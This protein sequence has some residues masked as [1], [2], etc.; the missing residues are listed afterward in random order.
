MGLPTLLISISDDQIPSS[1]ALNNEGIAKY[2]GH[3]NDLDVKDLY[4][5]IQNFV[6]DQVLL[7]K[8]KQSSMILVDG[9]GA[10]RVAEYLSPSQKDSIYLMP[11]NSSDIVQYF[12]WANDPNVRKNAINTEVISF[13]SHTDW[14]NNSIS[15]ADRIMFVLESAGLPIGQIRFD[16]KEN[17][18]TIDYSIDDIAHG[19]GLATILVQEG[20]KEFSKDFSKE[21]HA[22]VRSENTYSRN[23]FGSVILGRRK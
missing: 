7:Q 3:I 14:F 23:V 1:I 18:A 13:E 17:T 2:A 19:R 21:I 16:I 5:Q 15:N 20:I 10:L 22:L 9:F 12:L 8:M 11:A 6:S 4:L